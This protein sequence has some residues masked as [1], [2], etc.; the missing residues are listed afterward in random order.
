MTHLGAQRAEAYIAEGE[1]CFAR[2]DYVDAIAILSKA[3]YLDDKAIELYRIRGLSHLALG[4]LKVRV[5]CVQRQ[6]APVTTVQAAIINFK[7]I[8]VLDTEA[9]GIAEDL[10]TLIDTQV[11]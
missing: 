10:C 3:E 2:G 6:L 7:H 1:D 9:D 11:R 5:S 4:D 8:Q